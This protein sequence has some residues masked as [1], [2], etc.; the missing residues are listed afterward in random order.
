MAEKNINSKAQEI[1]KKT[2]ELSEKCNI[3]KKQIIENNS[4]IDYAYN[5]LD[6]AWKPHKVYL[7][8]YGGLGAK[9][10]IMG[11][12]PG[13]GMG[14]T[15]I[16]FGCP[17]KVKTYLDITNLKVKQPMKTHPKRKITGL[18]CTKPEISGKRIWGIIEE[19]YG[20][21]T[22]AFNEIFVL[23]H[24]P[25]WMFNESGQNITP[26]KLRKSTTKEIFTACNK[27][28]TDVAQILNCKTIIGVGKYAQKM[29]KLALSD[30]EIKTIIVKEIPHPSP[31]NPLANKDKGK[32]WKKLS[33][34]VIKS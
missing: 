3:Y 30:N 12:N 21:P 8:K 26:D 6:Y 18:E 24:F 27:Y 34:K 2:K 4:N 15:G 14:N 16:P 20:S 19:I 23:N 33:K 5:P 9:T 17:E 7:E 28:L 13:H 32:I 29:A 22:N 11:M 1:I 10:I 31:A 25:L